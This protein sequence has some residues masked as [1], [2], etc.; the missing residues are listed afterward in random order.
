MLLQTIRRDGIYIVEKYRV[1]CENHTVCLKEYHGN[2]RIK[3][4]F[5]SSIDKYYI[6]AE[7]NNFQFKF[8]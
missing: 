7:D 8:V 2:P 3:I 1:L 6:Q 4:I 5:L